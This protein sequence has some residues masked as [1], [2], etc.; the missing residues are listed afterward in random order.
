MFRLIKES[1]K[2]EIKWSDVLEY[3][4]LIFFLFAS[5]APSRDRG[6]DFSMFEAFILFMFSV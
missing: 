5:I 1:G 6:R 4:R 2:G 3:D